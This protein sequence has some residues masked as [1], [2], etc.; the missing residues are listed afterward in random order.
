MSERIR[1]NRFLAQCSVGSRRECDRII[2]CGVVAINGKLAEMGATV[3]LEHDI[4]TVKG[5]HVRPYL[6]KEYYI[7]HKSRGTV[8]TKK[9]PQG[10]ETIFEAIEKQGVK[11][12][13]LNYIGRLDRN[14][15]G[16]LILTNDGDIIHQLTH[17]RYH[18]KKVYRVKID[19]LVSKE[20]RDKMVK[21][22]VMSEGELLKAGAV[23]FCSDMNP[24]EVWYEVDLY[25]GRNRQIRR[26]FGELEYTVHR[27]K[28][29]RFGTL[30]L[31]DLK[32]GAIRELT[33][34]EINDLRPLIDG[35]KKTTRKG[36]SRNRK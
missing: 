26:I 32:R 16:L 29:I 18:V 36:K 23:R 34:R 28:R 14:S 10:R 30:N 4:V 3:S 31:K 27:L 25:E 20:D 5:K 19:R 1:L 6:R 2:E 35:E 8:V 12:K 11:T 13:H 15:E 21:S 7:H 33:Q 22:G 17:P 9:D 24:E